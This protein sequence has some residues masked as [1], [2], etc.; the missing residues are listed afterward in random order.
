[1]ANNLVLSF[2]FRFKAAIFLGPSRERIR[3]V[4]EGSKAEGWFLLYGC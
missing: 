4:E 2:V 3:W 1:M